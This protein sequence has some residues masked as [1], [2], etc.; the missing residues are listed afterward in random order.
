[1][2]RIGKKNALDQQ[3]RKGLQPMA[4]PVT[5]NLGWFSAG[6]GPGSRAMF[7]HALAAIDDGSLNASVQ[8]LFM[9]RERGEGEAS[10]RFMELAESRGIPVVTLSSKRFRE[11]HGGDFAGHRDE[12]DKRVLEA[13]RP[14]SPD[15]CVLA[16]YLLIL[17]PLLVR[18]YPFINLHPS[19]PGGPIGLWQQV[20]WRLIAER[21]EETGAMIFLVTE[22]LDGGPP[23][24]F[25]RVSLG[26]PRFDPLWAAIQGRDITLL[27]KEEGESLPLFQDIRQ[28]EIAL[29]APLL[30]ETI[31]RLADGRL[32][33]P[34]GS[35]AG[36][37]PAIDLTPTGHNTDATA[38]PTT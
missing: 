7:E 30:T 34:D 10:D 13:L 37:T 32:A 38:G 1:M 20:V 8:F 26:G 24:S 5:L 3:L 17:S 28:A 14:F 23:V 21:A 2:G 16:G 22:E 18:R 36:A 4:D 31:R 35:G 29:E 9:H 19:L 15:V 25:A 11:E 12:Y 33:L 6:R 27:Q